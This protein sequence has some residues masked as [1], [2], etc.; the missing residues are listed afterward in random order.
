MGI[1]DTLIEESISYYNDKKM[2][3]DFTLEDNK[4]PIRLIIK[5]TDEMILCEVEKKKYRSVTC[6]WVFLPFLKIEKFCFAINPSGSPLHYPETSS[7][8]IKSIYKNLIDR[9]PSGFIENLK[10]YDPQKGLK[11]G[12]DNIFLN[13]DEKTLPFIVMDV[14]ADEI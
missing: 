13:Y 10:Q 4:Y 2:T 3:K 7:G 11:D 12:Y 1:E 14:N 6:E 5:K 8:N 9:C